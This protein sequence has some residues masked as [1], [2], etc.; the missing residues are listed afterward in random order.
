MTV[1]A[2]DAAFAKGLQEFLDRRVGALAAGHGGWDAA[3]FADVLQQGWA[4]LAVP[5]EQDGLGAGLAD[6]RPLMTLMGDRLVPGPLVESVV[7]PAVL[8]VPT[9]QVLAFADPEAAIGWSTQQGQL[10]FADGVLDGSL[11]LV[12]FA[13]EAELLVVVAQGADGGPVLLALPGDQAGLLVQDTASEDP[14]SHYARLTATAVQVD[15]GAV[16]AAGS[17][18]VARLVTARAWIRVLLSCELAGIARRVLQDTITYVSAREQFGRPIGS[19][20]AIKHLVAAMAQATFALE[21]Y[22]AAVA[23]DA[24]EQSPA[25]LEQAAWALKA[26]ASQACRSVCETGLQAHGGIGF[27]TEYHLHWYLR[28]AY[29]LDYWYGNGESLYELVGARRVG[30][31]A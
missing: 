11:E 23:A 2:T 16:L 5:V 24:A 12:R 21:S 8:G 20:Q 15:P 26:F 29:A 4:D 10:R 18:A 25:E 13:A 14:S 3:L 7:L 28:R 19:F 31:T 27:T 6:L 9:E 30:T 17:D 22:T 1:T